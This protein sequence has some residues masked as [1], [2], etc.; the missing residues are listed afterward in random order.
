MVIQSTKTWMH[1]IGTNNL[2]NGDDFRFADV[3]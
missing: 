2:S 1:F 3:F